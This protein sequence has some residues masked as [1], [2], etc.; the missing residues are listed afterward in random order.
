MTGGRTGELRA[1]TR[2]EA[3]PPHRRP[4]LPRTFYFPPLH[5]STWD[6]WTGRGFD[7]KPASCTCLRSIA[8]TCIQN[9]SNPF[10]PKSDQC[11]IPPAASS[12]KILHHTVWRTVAHER[13]WRTWF[14]KDDYTAHPHYL[15]YTFL[16]KRLGECTFWTWEWKI[17]PWQNE[18]TLLRALW[19]QHC[20]LRCCPYVAKRGNIGARR[21]DTRDVSEDFQKRFFVSATNVARMAKRVDIWETWSRQQCCRHNVSSFCWPLNPFTPKFKK[22]T[23]PTLLQRNALVR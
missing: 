1:K 22:Y 14:M 2:A 5:V 6:Q 20:V 8:R 13:T 12:P 16:L 19:R 7:H 9:D 21:A 23:L 18:D 3:L 15:N 17:K 10:T 4:S 11:Q